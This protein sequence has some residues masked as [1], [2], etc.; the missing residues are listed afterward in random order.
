MAKTVLSL[1]I[2][3]RGSKPPI[4]RR[5]LV[6]GTMNLHE[7]HNAI[8]ATMGWHGGHMHAFDVGGQ[9][10]GDANDMD[11]VKEETRL[12]LN[13]IVKSGVKQFVYTYDFGDDWEHRI[14]I[15]KSMPTVPG[16][17]YPACVAGKR[18]GP[19]DD[20]G[21]SWGYADLLEILA[22]PNHPEREE[23]LEWI[24][25]DDFDP[26]EFSVEDADTALAGCFAR[27]PLT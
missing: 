21:G 6:P 17:P 11:D 1:K 18:N 26:E 19:P 14:A 3:L 20:C 16:Q 5:L 8:L 23:R 15:E 7:L 27:K 2:T 4:W 24:G 9:Q 25:V 13:A 22:D 10:Y 12:T